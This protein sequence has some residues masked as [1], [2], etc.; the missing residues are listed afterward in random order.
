MPDIE[1]CLLICHHSSAVI[2]R[3]PFLG[4]DTCKCMVFFIVTVTCMST[5]TC[6]G[7]VCIV[8]DTHMGT[9][10]CMGTV[11]IV[12]NTCMNTNTCM[13]MVCV[14]TD[15]CMVTVVCIVT[16]TCIPEA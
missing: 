6:M 11:C 10:T 7:T 2:R 16:V 13:G 8:T 4:M 5:N 14:V 9:N 1:N 15:T 3:L 12:T